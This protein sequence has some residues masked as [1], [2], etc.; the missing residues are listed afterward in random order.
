MSSCGNWINWKF[1]GSLF[2]FRFHTLKN[3]PVVKWKALVT[4]NRKLGVCRNSYMKIIF[5]LR[6]EHLTVW[7]MTI[8]D[9]DMV[10]PHIQVK[11]Q[12]SSVAFTIS[13]THFFLFWK[14]FCSNDLFFLAN[15]TNNHIIINII[16]T[17][18]TFSLQLTFCCVHMP[19]WEKE[20]CLFASLPLALCLFVWLCNSF[21]SSS[22]FFWCCHYNSIICTSHKKQI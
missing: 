5:C 8:V 4:K 16:I 1:P 6:L 22:S 2:H 21:V 7:L 15:S 14:C 10:F 9:N 12:N 3:N 18:L 11:L 20:V 13:C 17:R 19:M